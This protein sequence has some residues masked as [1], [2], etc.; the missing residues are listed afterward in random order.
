MVVLILGSAP[1]IVMAFHDGGVGP[2]D[3]CHSI[4]SYQTEGMAG[5]RGGYLLKGQDASSTCL[6]CHEQPNDTGPTAYHVSTPDVE[7]TTKGYPKQLT[8]GGD[9]GWLKKSYS[10]SVNATKILTSAPES[11][12]HNIAAN[13]YGYMAVQGN[14]P[15]GTYPGDSMSCI[16]CHDPHGK[17][18]RNQDGTVSVGG[19]PIKD[20]GSYDVSPDPD[21]NASVGTYRLLGGF[22]YHPLRVNAGFAFV[23]NSPT[24]V[25]P[26]I[27]NKAETAS[28]TRVAY[29]AGMSEWCRNCHANIHKG[30]DSFTHPSPTPLGA[31]YTAYYN[32]YVKYNDLSGLENKSYWSLTPFEIGT[33]NYATLKRIVVS[34]PTKGPDSADG[35]PQVMCLSCH[36]AHAS[37][38]DSS[39]RWNTKTDNIVTNGK[40]SQ[41]G[42][43]YQPSGQ[44]R[45]EAEALQGYY[46]VPASA[47]NATEPAMTFCFK[48]HNPIPTH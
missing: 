33:S 37:S 1:T 10:W 39:T 47:F 27:Y 3:G 40:Y 31:T 11:H 25:A 42:L 24:A 5:A 6:N 2:C 35:E 12:G 46:Q 7:L 14:A 38:W 23:A 19:K 4:H 26:S 28:V 20:S 41:E 43:I 18:R 17:Y 34:T 9:F 8:P 45:S 36:R 22:A 15:G 16:S 48:C 13:D 21:N 44:G 29:G 30:S 32:S